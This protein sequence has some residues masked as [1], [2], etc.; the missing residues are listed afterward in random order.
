MQRRRTT[1]PQQPRQGWKGRRFVS[2]EGMTG[3]KKIHFNINFVRLGQQGHQE[4]QKN[5]ATLLWDIGWGVFFHI[6][7]TSTP[8]LVVFCCTGTRRCV[9]GK[10]WF[11]YA[12]EGRSASPWSFFVPTTGTRTRRTVVEYSSD[13]CSQTIDDENCPFFSRPGQT[14][15]RRWSLSLSSLA[16]PGNVDPREPMPM[17]WQDILVADHILMNFFRHQRS[18][19]DVS[20]S[21]VESSQCKKNIWLACEAGPEK[22]VSLRYCGSI[23]GRT[24]CFTWV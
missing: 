3:S 23:L 21:L 22:I 8:S 12:F 18:V 2:N 20:L 5:S 14:R 1:R 10:K 4:E 7:T 16:S 9:G 11:A 19:G 13:L 24:G 6:G 15:R 17:T